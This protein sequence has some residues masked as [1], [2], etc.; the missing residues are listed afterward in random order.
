MLW[1]VMPPIDPTGIAAAKRYWLERQR[2]VANNLAN[3]STDGFK[4]ERVFARL[5][6][7]GST[8]ADALHDLRAGAQRTTSAPLDLALDGPGFFVVQ[9]PNGERLSRGG[10]FRLDDTG[11]IVD[12]H[13]NALLGDTGPVVVERGPVA[14]D[15]TGRITVDG[16]AAGQLRL[17]SGPDSPSLERD[18][19]HDTGTL[20][21]PTAACQPLRDVAIVR[22]GALEE[23]N[24]EVFGALVDMIS[25]A[26]AYAALE[27]ADT[28]LDSI[29][30]LARDLGKP[31]RP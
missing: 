16:R 14:I 23:S 1:F 4:A 7:D 20:F 28:M 8:V 31:A 19:Q 12:A 13:G 22:Q 26:R 2:V 18:M 11:R 24:V 5:L 27:H 9:T 30:G 25:I 15:S 29:D 10:S 21:I 6:E 17:V 3:M